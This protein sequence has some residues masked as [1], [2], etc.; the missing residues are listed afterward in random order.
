M[1]TSDVAS[2]NI[3]V[4]CHQSLCPFLNL[5]IQ[6]LNMSNDS[7]NLSSCLHNPENALTALSLPESRTLYRP[8]VR[9]RVKSHV[10]LSYTA[11]NTKSLAIHAAWPLFLVFSSYYPC[12]RKGQSTA[13]QILSYLSYLWF[14]DMLC[15]LFFYC[16]HKD[17]SFCIRNFRFLEYDVTF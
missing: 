13:V 16:N 11:P 4:W 12:K 7:A 5:S 8:K 2:A 14:L 1:G 10:H 3:E 15:A 9:S 17:D 6:G